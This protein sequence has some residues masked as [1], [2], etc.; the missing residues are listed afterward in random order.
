M[1]VVMGGRAGGRRLQVKFGESVSITYLMGGVAP[2]FRVP[3]K[4][5][6]R[7][8]DAAAQAAREGEQRVPFPSFAVRGDDDVHRL[9]DTTDPAQL[10]AAALAAERQARRE[11]ALAGTTWSPA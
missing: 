2:E 7:V 3:V 5:M 10:R 8:L 1:P 11:R 9:Y 4:T 6:R